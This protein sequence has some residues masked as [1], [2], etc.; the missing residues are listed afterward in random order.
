MPAFLSWEPALGTSLFIPVSSHSII[1]P[2]SGDKIIS[3]CGPLLVERGVEI[4]LEG[5]DLVEVLDFE[6]SLLVSDF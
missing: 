2:P 5:I 6:F 1:L 4:D 3:S